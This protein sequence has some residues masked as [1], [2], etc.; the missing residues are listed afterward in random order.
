MRLIRFNYGGAPAGVLLLDGRLVVMVAGLRL[1]ALAAAGERPLE[2]DVRRIGDHAARH[3]NGLLQ[4]GADH[5]HGAGHAHRRIWGG[6]FGREARAGE[7][8]TERESVRE[9]DGNWV[10][11]CVCV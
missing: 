2:R 5:Q 9:E 10:G 11:A 4:G 6:R 1:E 3:R 8:D 7:R